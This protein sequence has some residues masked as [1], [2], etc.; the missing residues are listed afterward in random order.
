[1]LLSGARFPPREYP[2]NA[3]AEASDRGP[4]GMVVQRVFAL[5]FLTVL[6]DCMVGPDWQ[7]PN[8]AVASQWLE[9]REPAVVVTRRHR[10]HAPGFYA[11]V[12]LGAAAAATPPNYPPPYIP[13]VAAG[14]IPIR[15]ATKPFAASIEGPRV[16]HGARSEAY[17]ASATRGGFVLM[18]ASTRPTTMKAAPAMS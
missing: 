16:A 9:A 11:G 5:P 10:W 3:Y 1:M 15:P 12:A 8:A 13:T 2:G 18:A 7:K 17:A 6:S 14:T 4:G